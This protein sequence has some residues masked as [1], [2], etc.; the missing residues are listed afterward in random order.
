MS[1]LVQF[2]VQVWTSLCL[3]SDVDVRAHDEGDE[4]LGDEL[5]TQVVS[6]S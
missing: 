4:G 3:C 1:L 6:S 5:S 2:I